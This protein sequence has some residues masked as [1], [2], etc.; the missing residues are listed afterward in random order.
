MRLPGRGDNDASFGTLASEF[1]DLVVTYAKQETIDP[2]KVI[3]RFVIWGVLGALL[4]GLGVALMTLAI[5]RLLQG[6]LGAH[7]RGSLTWVPYVGGLLF[8][9]VVAGL[10][11]SRI[12]KGPR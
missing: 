7:L 6:E 1:K 11:V 10:A 12:G 4:L 5:L 3:V 9:L 8:V 2:L